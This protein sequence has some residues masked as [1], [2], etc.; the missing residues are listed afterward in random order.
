MLGM[1]PSDP[2]ESVWKAHLW[3]PANGAT[4]P[5]WDPEGEITKLLLG[6][7]VSS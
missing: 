4:D 3:K 5:G 2:S 6:C 7:A 1:D